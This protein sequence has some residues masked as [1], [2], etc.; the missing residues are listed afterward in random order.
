[1]KKSPNGTVETRYI[2]IAHIN[3]DGRPIADPQR[4]NDLMDS[5]Q[6]IGLI[7]AV[8]VDRSYRL[9]AGLHRLTACKRLG[10]QT[11]RA[12]VVDYDRVES[13]L[14]EIDENIIRRQFTRL[15]RAELLKR[16]MEIYEAKII[17]AMEG[18]GLLENGEALPVD[19]PTFYEDAA[20]KLGVGPRTVERDVQIAL[21]IA[22]DV[23][24][25]IRAAPIADNK[26]QLL[27]LSRIGDPAEQWKVA[28]DLISG[29][30]ARIRRAQGRLAP[31]MSSAS[32]EWYTPREIIERVVRV[33][34][35][36]DLDP[37]SNSH[38]EPNVPATHHFTEEDDG[39]AQVWF[40]RVYMNPPYGRVID[41]WAEK[42]VCETEAGKVTQAIALVP[43]RTDT[44][45]FR[46]F[47]PYPRCFVHGRLKFSDYD[48][49]APFP[50]A[51]VGLRCG[52]EAFV[53]AFGDIGDVFRVVE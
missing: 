4:V 7:N 22:H 16:R 15:E 38:E 24:D 13:E 36:I 42:L 17:G 28:D 46:R 49:S 10:W 33:M 47:R 32:P 18:D 40:G 35:G 48:N 31:L 20:Q 52:L 37:C 12:N 23:R 30:A 25:L 27:A 11:I 45:W 51:I 14:A 2:A 53:E 41:Q 8:T 21:N 3:C 9:I 39:L 19:A 26:A 50:S 5:I 43:A 6:Q 44:A 29:K 1:M 34:G